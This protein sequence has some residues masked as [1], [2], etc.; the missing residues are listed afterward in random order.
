MQMH[1]IDSHVSHP[2]IIKRLKRAI[3]QLNSIVTMMEAGRPCAEVAQQLQAAAKNAR[4]NSGN[5]RRW[6][7]CVM[8]HRFTSELT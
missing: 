3:G 1:S 7:S 8:R 6:T 5:E 4:Q 2:E